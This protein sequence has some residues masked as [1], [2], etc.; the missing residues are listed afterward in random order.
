MVTIP[1]E[2]FTEGKISLPVNVQMLNGKKITVLPKTVTLTYK[3]TL[4]HYSKVY[5]DSFLLTA[6]PVMVGETNKL[7]LSVIKSPMQATVTSV[8]P[9]LIDYYF[10]K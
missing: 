5:T 2:E 6:E 3:T 7:K 1:V 4:A 8:V 10:E 9:S